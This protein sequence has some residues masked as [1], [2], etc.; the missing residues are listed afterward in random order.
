VFLGYLLYAEL[1]VLCLVCASTYV[2]NFALL[3]LLHTWPHAKP[4]PSKR[5]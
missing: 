2:V 3:A 4:R 5:E 1:Q